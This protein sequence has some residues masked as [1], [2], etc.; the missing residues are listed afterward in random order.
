MYL[1]TWLLFAF[2]TVSAF[3]PV[4][5]RWRGWWVAYYGALLVSWVFVSVAAFRKAARAGRMRQRKL[6]RLFRQHQ[7]E[8]KARLEREGT[9]E[10][11][12]P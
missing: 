6:A 8:E 12:R 7:D 11:P 10:P 5:G 9:G 1:P 4:A 2:L 3:A